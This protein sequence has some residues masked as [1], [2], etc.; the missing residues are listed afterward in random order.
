MSSLATTCPR[1]SSHV[2]FRLDATFPRICMELFASGPSCLESSFLPSS[3]Y[4][5]IALILRSWRAKTGYRSE[6][7]ERVKSCGSILPWRHLSKCTLL[8]LV[9]FISKQEIE[10]VPGVLAPP[11][12]RLCRHYT[13]RHVTLDEL[14]WLADLPVM[15]YWTAP[16]SLLRRM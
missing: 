3:L 8:A 7:L 10:N 4:S 13:I 6:R 2:E 14:S 9:R 12:S 1:L 11:T 15:P 5:Y 16:S